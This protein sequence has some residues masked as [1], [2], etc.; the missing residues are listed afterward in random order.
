MVV[1]FW[2]S[3]SVLKDI[4]KYGAFINSDTEIGLLAWLQTHQGNVVK[5][6][7]RTNVYLIQG[8]EKR[9]YDDIPS[10]IAHGKNISDIVTVDEDI[11]KEVKL[12]D[13]ITFWTG[14]NV[15][16]IKAMLQNY[17]NNINEFKKYFREIL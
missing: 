10:L 15:K 4:S 8:D 9:K 7:S 3:A 2:L 17:P 12:G 14:G 1:L 13:P 16:Q 6:A 5:G 11:L